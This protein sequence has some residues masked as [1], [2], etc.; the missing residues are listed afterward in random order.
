MRG[1]DA[2]VLL[3][4]SRQGGQPGTLYVFEPGS[5]SL[6]PIEDG[7]AINPHGMD[8]RTVL[9]FVKMV[10]GWP[11]KVVV[12]AWFPKAFTGG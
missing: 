11:G 6:E 1:Y 8:P 5:E 3:D 9:R 10:G 7:E 2:L 12:I 4:A